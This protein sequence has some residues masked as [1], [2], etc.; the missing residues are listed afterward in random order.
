MA[1]VAGVRSAWKSRIESGA[2]VERDRERG[3]TCASR[4]DDPALRVRCDEAGF[5]NITN[6]ARSIASESNVELELRFASPVRG[7]RRRFPTSKRTASSG[8]EGLS[9]L[10]GD[11]TGGACELG[12]GALQPGLYRPISSGRGGRGGACGLLGFVNGGRGEIFE[13]GICGVGP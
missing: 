5:G 9:G 6:V 3:A 11:P 4:G 12:N 8:W 13:K 7:A 1:G 2:L 10:G